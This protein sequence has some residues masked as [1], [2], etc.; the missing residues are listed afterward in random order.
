MDVVW[1]PYDWH[2]DGRERTRARRA[3]PRAVHPLRAAGKPSVGAA[4]ARFDHQRTTAIRLF[5]G[6]EA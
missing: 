5:D 2:F 6:H 3:W 1:M 4:A